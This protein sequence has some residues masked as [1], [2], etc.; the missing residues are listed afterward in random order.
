MPS[1]KLFGFLVFFFLIQWLWRVFFPYTLLIKVHPSSQ[2]LFQLEDIYFPWFTDSGFHSRYLFVENSTCW[3]AVIN[4][5][6]DTLSR[7][8]LQ[9]FLTCV[10]PMICGDILSLQDGNQLSVAYFCPLSL[11]SHTTHHSSYWVQV[12]DLLLKIL[13]NLVIKAMTR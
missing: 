12:W 9:S 2:I 13:C 6:W 10:S 8:S 4:S 11:Q 3:E 7:L 5:E 1:S